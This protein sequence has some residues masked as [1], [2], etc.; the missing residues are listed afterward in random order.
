MCN[1]L[2]TESCVGNKSFFC[3]EILVRGNS[4]MVIMCK[5]H[6][7]GLQKLFPSVLISSKIMLIP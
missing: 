5:N 3:V 2:Q 1:S 7:D 4:V 6:Y